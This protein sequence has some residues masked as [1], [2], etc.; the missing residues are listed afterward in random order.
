MLAGTVSGWAQVLSGQP[1]DAVKVRLQTS[2]VYK[3]TLDCAT[4]IVRE[5][6]ALAFY[7]GTVMPLV[8]IGMSRPSQTIQKSR[9]S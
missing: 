2:N 1:F 3:G 9:L 6:G 5:E 7:K 8:G 4:R